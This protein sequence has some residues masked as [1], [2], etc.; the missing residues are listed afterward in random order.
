MRKK[1]SSDTR[2]T[3]VSLFTGAGGL[4]TG[5]EAAGWRTVAAT[6][7]DGDCCATLR[8][9]KERKITIPGS[10]YNFLADAKIVHKLV[11]DVKRDDLVPDGADDEWVP[12]LLAGGP[13]CQPFSSAGKQLGLEDPRGRLFEHFVRLA[14][15][16]Q[17][18]A[19]LFE[20]VRGLV[21]AAGPSG[22]PGEALALVRAE[23]E[24]IG[25]ATTFQ[26]LNAADF[27][28]PQRRVRLFMLAVKEAP[29]PKFPEPTN[30]NPDSPPNLFSTTRRWTTLGDF[31]ATQ[32]AAAPEDIERPSQA[33]REKLNEVPNGS[34]LKSAGARETTRPGG[35][36][37]YKQGTFIAD[38][39]KPARTVTAAASQDWIRI[40]GDLRRL[41]WR[42]CAGL[43]GFPAEWEFTGNKASRFRQIGN[44]VPAVLGR[45]LGVAVREVFAARAL[46][47]IPCSAPWPAYFTQVVNYT[48][49]EKKRNGASRAQVRTALATGK[50][51]RDELKG[52]GSDEALKKASKRRRITPANGAGGA[53]S[54]AA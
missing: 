39:A 49:R 42:E 37:G 13:P 8:L 19:I 45:V 7:S 9:N 25:Y 6:D 34:G 35:H 16:L 44:A 18:R 32:P 21:T 22:E 17:P 5:L 36:W 4:D 30:H 54:P 28:A 3:L 14:S 24:K 50:A 38:L 11:E 51:D 12:D 41:T 26:V 43:Q 15:E 10:R 29:L 23:F 48:K 27:G 31:L 53:E 2:P 20:N 1:T 33:L 52:L 46:G 47:V 40:G